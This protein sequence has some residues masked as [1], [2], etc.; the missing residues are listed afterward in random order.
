MNL[1]KI[2]STSQTLLNEQNNSQAMWKDSLFESFYLMSSPKAK[3]SRGERLAAEIME[4]LDHDVLR[5]KKNGKP[6]RLAGDSDHDIVVE[7]YRTEVKLRLTW[8]DEIDKFTWQQI[9]SRQVYER[10]IFIAINPEELKMWW[11]TKED[12][13]YNIFGKSC[14]RQHGGKKGKQDLYWI[15]SKDGIPAWFRPIEEW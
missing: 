15:H 4:T 1:T 12:L 8:G 13:E 10:I 3:G 11:A 9:R 6:A 5:N 7:G 2:A 14:Y